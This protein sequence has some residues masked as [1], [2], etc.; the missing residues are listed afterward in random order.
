V[1]KIYIILGGNNEND[2]DIYLKDLAVNLPDP[3][4]EQLLGMSRQH[5][6]LSSMSRQL[7][8]K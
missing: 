1:R 7:K 4:P 2:L 5:V 3:E 6:T 8:K